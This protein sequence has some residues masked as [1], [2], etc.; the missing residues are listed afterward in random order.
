MNN[1]SAVKTIKVEVVLAFAETQR[2]VAVEIAE[3]T[4]LEKAIELSAILD[5]FEGFELDLARVGIF[6]RKASADT[7]LCEGDR[8]EIYR[9][10]IAD[11]KE[12]RRQRAIKQAA[13]ES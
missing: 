4:S 7:L 13:G 10:L 5:S 3:G 8:V 11:P 12:V 6:G 1:E 9:P 2:L